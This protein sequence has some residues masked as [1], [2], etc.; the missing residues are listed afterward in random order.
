MQVIEDEHSVKLWGIKRMKDSSRVGMRASTAPKNEVNVKEF[1]RPE[2][3]NRNGWNECLA[4][5]RT[6]PD[7]SIVH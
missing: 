2:R 1:D 4:A 5:T 3:W 7:Y 6:A